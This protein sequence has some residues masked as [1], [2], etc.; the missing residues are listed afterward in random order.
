MAIVLPPMT[1]FPPLTV[2]DLETTGL[3]PKKGHRIIEIA[4]VRIEEG[5]V[6]DK[7]FVSLV[8]PERD[9]PWEAKQVNKIDEADVATAPTID[10][11]LPQFLEFATGSVLIAHNAAFDHGFLTAEKEFCWGYIELPECLCSMRLSQS[12]YP[13]EFRHSLDVLIRKFNLDMPADRHRALSDCYAAADAILKMID[14]GP[15]RTFEELRKRA[16]LKQLVS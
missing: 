8:N 16:G 14:Q 7:T 13:T 15:V 5:N 6:T 1:T 2:F 9:I 12:L 4:G 11:V 3:D 10:A